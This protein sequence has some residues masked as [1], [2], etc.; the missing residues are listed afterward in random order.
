M[1][2]DELGTSHAGGLVE[3]GL[4][5]NRNVL[6]GGGLLISQIRLR[7][8]QLRCLHTCIAVQGWS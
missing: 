6:G 7:L 5:Q 8:A 2:V 3:L 1:C 4:K